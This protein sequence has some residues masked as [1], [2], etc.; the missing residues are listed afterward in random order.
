MAKLVSTV[1]NLGATQG[2][3]DFVDV[4]TEGDIP[5]YIDP[6]AIRLQTGEWAESCR[7]QL[8]SFFQALLNA[9]IADDNAAV[10]ILVASLSEPNE[11]RLGQSAE[12]ARGRGLGAGAR[13][14]KIVKSLKDSHA[15]SSG[16]L[17]DLEDSALIVPD[18]GRDIVSDIT[19]NIIRGQLIEYTQNMCIFY[20][21]PMQERSSGLVWNHE[22]EEF[23]DDLVMLPGT[24]E[25]TLL[26]VPKSIVR[27]K[28]IMST[29][30]YYRGY[31]R[32]IYEDLEIANPSSELVYILKDGTHKVHKGKLDELI[33]R[34]KPDILQHT[35]AHPTA[36]EEYRKSITAE[37]HPP[38]PPEEFQEK[39]NS[40]EI[41]FDDLLGAVRAIDPGKHG[42]GSYHRACADLLNAIFAGH[43][44]NQKLEEKLHEGRKRIDIRYDNI[45]SSGFFRWLG[46]NYKAPTV[47]VECKNYTDDPKN[48]ELDQLTGRFGPNRGNFGILLCRKVENRS[49]MSQRC[50]DAANDGRGFVVVLDDEDLNELVKFAKANRANSVSRSAYPLLRSRFD[51]LIM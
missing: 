45:A 37:D 41:D 25:G 48:N 49:V 34:T 26:L 17:I 24:K 8:Q 12:G 11:T 20:K 1:F 14:D 18:V 32:P 50:K 47:V 35:L 42:A 27:I 51:S 7:A 15:K 40:P 38:M 46:D 29:D 39:L 31:L 30:D 3:L 9:V 44:G 28:P 21:I 36:L 16:L 22:K 10:K 4:D 6:K 2:S 19:T 43:L 13:A 33:G 23:E 5:V